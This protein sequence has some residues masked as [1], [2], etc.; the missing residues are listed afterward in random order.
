MSAPPSAIRPALMSML[1]GMRS[2]VCELVAI[3]KTGMLGKPIALPRPVVNAMMFTPP[4][5]RPVS[6]TGS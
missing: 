3:F 4:A 1:S 2:K 5:A 6:D